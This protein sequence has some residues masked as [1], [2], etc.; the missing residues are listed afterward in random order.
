MY[1]LWQFKNRKIRIFLLG[2]PSRVRPREDH[3]TSKPMSRG[4]RNKDKEACWKEWKQ[5]AAPGEL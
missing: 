5:E 3:I 4:L 2:P 1:I